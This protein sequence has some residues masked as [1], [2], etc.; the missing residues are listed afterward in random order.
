MAKLR[1]AKPAAAPA[2]EGGYL[3]WGDDALALTEAQAALIKATIDPDWAELN[4]ERLTDVRA[5]EALAAAGTPPFGGGGRMVVVRITEKEPAEAF[6]EELSELWDGRAPL[7]GNVLLVELPTVDKRRKAA[8]ALASRMQLVCFELPKAWDVAKK[9]GPWVEERLAVRGASISRDALAALLEA[10]GTD[11]VRLAAELEKILL[12]QGGGAQR[13]ELATVQ[14][15][16]AATDADVFGLLGCL[17]ANDRGAA[18]LEAR[19]LLLLS[20]DPPQKALLRLLA[21][22]ASNLLLVKNAKALL[23]LGRSQ[24]D[25]AEAMGVHPFR[26]QNLLREWGRWRLEDL[27]STLLALGEVDRRAKTGR[28]E[29][30]LLLETWI[31]RFPRG[32][33]PAAPVSLV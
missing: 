33:V 11:T 7:P 24:A 29:P 5:A 26:L 21:G 31:S 23:A 9:L 18:L 12:W 27:Q 25:V 20:T 10:V 15:L 19:R 28:W 8:K 3:H 4:L 30:V 13:I 16:V 32:F 6:L 2:A 1:A 14:R 22:L 17:A